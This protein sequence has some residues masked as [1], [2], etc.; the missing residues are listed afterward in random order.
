MQQ[1]LLLD[2]SFQPVKT[3]PWQ[4]A[5]TLLTLGKVEIVE[6]YD[7]F[8]IR[9]VKAVI[10]MPAVVRLL[11]AFKRFR[12]PVKFSRINIFARDNY[13]CQYCAKK[14]NDMGKLT[15][16]H[17]TPRTRGGK[18]EWSNIATCCGPCNEKKRDRTPS[19]AGMKLLNVPV[20]PKWIPAIELKLTGRSAPDEWHDYIYWTTELNA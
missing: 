5:V 6:E 8:L 17:V 14:H 10:K 19:E 2:Q 3:I 12:K 7:G 9:S 16:D 15:F 4:R 13:T 11:R 1:T 20:Q 18:T